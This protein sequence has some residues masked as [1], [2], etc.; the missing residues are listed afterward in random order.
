MSNN[1]KYWKGEEE[2]NRDARFLAAQKNEFNESLPLDEVLS[3]DGFELNSNRRDFLKYFGFSVTAVTLAA[4]YK[5][6]VRHAVPYLVKPEEV[7]PGVANYYRST[8][9]ACS[10]GCGIE[11]K[12]REGRPI[13]VDGSADSP[14]SGGGLCAAGQAS[15][16]S[17]Y[18][19]E[20]LANPLH[21]GAE[22]KDWSEL[23][24]G[25]KAKLASIS[26]SGKGIA[27]V[28]GTV[29]GPTTLKAIS[30]FTAAYPTAKHVM[31]DAVSYSGML[32]ANAAD[33]G[34]RAIPRYDFSK[35]NVI[36][37]FAA[38]FLGTWVSPVEFSKA[39]GKKRRPDA[40]GGMNQHFQFESA[41]SMTGT[42][43]DHRFPM[44]MSQERLYLSS[45]YNYLAQKAGAT[46]MP[47]VKQGELAGNALKSA[48]EA[49][50]NAK[51][52]SIVVSGSNDKVSQ[53]LVN[54]I[55][56][57]LGNYGSTLHM[58]QHSKQ[59]QGSDSEL[60]AVLKGLND[61]SI[62]AVIFYGANPVYNRGQEWQ[63]AI[64]KAELS[65][66][67]AASKDETA[68]VCQYVCPDSHYL[69]SWSDAEPQAGVY[70]LGQPTITRVF[71]TRQ[72]Q[73]SLLTWSG[74]A[75][76]IDA[77]PFA[78]K[79]ILSQKFEADPY[80]IY[81]ANNWKSQGLNEAAWTKALEMGVVSGTA[82]AAS[83]A[84]SG[85]AV[86]LASEV[87]SVKADNGIELN[88]YAPVGVRDG[89]HGNNPWLHE[90]PDP[91]SKVSWDNYVA[92]PKSL[93][94]ELGIKERDTVNIKAGE[95]MYQNVPALIQPG[96]ANGTLAMA[97][98]YGRTAAGK[99]GGSV[100]K[101]FET[102]GFNAFNLGG[103]TSTVVGNVEI[104]KGDAQYHL[105]QT[106]THHSIEGRDIVRET[107]LDAFKKN[108]KAG[109]DK[110]A[111]HVYTIWEKRDYRKDGS[112]NHLWG[113]AIDLN[114]CTGCGSCVVSC[115]IENNVPVVGR[116]EIRLRREMHWIRIDR[117]Y[118]FVSEESTMTRE[119]DIATADAA[120]KGEYSHWENV[121][122]IHQPM[123]CQHCAQA[124]CETVCPVLAT[125]HSS[126]GLNQM[127]YNRCIGTKY[128]GNNCPYKVRRFNW[129]RYN[130]NDAFDFHFNNPLG[131]M[132]INPDVT[133]RT[134]G[135][136]E[137]CS[138]CVQR[139]QEGK[140]KAKRAGKSPN[141]VQV[142]TACQRAC[143]SNAIVF[144]DLHNPESE[145]S[146][147]YRNERGFRVLDEINVQS[148]VTYM[149]KVRNTTKA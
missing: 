44:K 9:G 109:N 40:E 136:M 91:V 15:I 90:M 18:D 121:Q 8:C 81:L 139:I 105:A 46:Q 78:K 113:M 41:L 134:R 35:A 122:V 123:M 94:S 106:Q 133:V 53:Q 67:F 62:A 4:C 83:M 29:H 12:V 58:D 108:P 131:K 49:L 145:I 61:K 82:S 138:F 146:K 129:F 57:L 76:Q 130:D 68:T 65:V 14:I 103:G 102:I 50:W 112:P 135:V 2:L 98:G 127:T 5:T 31:Y 36:V 59:H 54:A 10:V 30:D 110:A 119:A 21:L 43:A 99:V 42:N 101:G 92:L 27:V 20:R 69:E 74:A 26:Q 63:A 116:D 11:V 77:D 66:S 95:L 84:Y 75:P 125:T 80:Y 111:T 39:Y 148:S 6:N 48:A 114:A 7:T 85:N 23:D 55:N 33:F 51:G 1:M 22:A 144:G 70:H 28:S 13:K 16:L 73:L 25:I 47:V 56:V 115:S 71:N 120:N 34:T 72:A 45:L 104:T 118:S 32:D 140:L 107:T 17:L 128:C 117:Y 143:P 24:N 37:S 132:V 87:A 124:P 64:A 96:Q 38:D 126:E 147:L 137:K 52:A 93:A 19:T 60:A 86:A 149:T 100:E 142:E 141:E 88:F 97:L 3:E 79:G 89:A